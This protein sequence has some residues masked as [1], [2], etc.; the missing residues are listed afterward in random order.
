MAIMD[1]LRPGQR[2][3]PRD[4]RFFW[5]CARRAGVWRDPAGPRRA[6]H[7]ITRKSSPSASGGFWSASSTGHRC[8]RYR[9]ISSERIRT[10]HGL[11]AL[12]FRPAS[13]RM[14]PYPAPRPGVRRNRIPACGPDAACS[15]G[16]TIRTIGMTRFISPRRSRNV[17]STGS[18]VFHGWV[19][20]LVLWSSLVAGVR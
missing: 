7:P 5:D 4:L 16:A 12:P 19:R 13:R 9:S 15:C 6:V 1:R 18:P 11:A 17:K 20:R 10:G 3:Y 14:N 2:L 8:P